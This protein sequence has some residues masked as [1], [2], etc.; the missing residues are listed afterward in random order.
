MLRFFRRQNNLSLKKATM[1]TNVC[2]DC[3]SNQ[4]IDYNFY[5]RLED[6]ICENNLSSNDIWNMD[7]IAVCLDPKKSNNCTN[8]IQNLQ[9][10]EGGD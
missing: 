6:I 2:E 9:K 7:E 5:D 1:M 3:T 8:M 4:F 10:P